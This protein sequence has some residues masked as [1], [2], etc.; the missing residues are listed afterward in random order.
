M[1][2][3]N[4]DSDKETKMVSGVD[5]ANRLSYFLWRSAPDEELIALGQSGKLLESNVKAQQVE[6]MM[7]DEKFEV[8]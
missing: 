5:F 8:Q 7:N 3:E 4:N 6:R 1:H 2:L